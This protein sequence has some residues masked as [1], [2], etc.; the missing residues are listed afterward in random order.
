[1]HKRKGFTLIELLVVIAIIAL[2]MAILM[3]ALKRAK[4]QAKDVVCQSNLRHWGIVFNMYSGDFDDKLM[5]MNEYNGN[6]MSHAW[7]TLMYPYY[8]TFDIC[9]CPSAIYEWSKMVNYSHPLA[10]W[11]FRI[12]EDDLII[13]E[14]DTYYLVGNEYAYG[15]YGKNP[16]VSEPSTDSIGDDFY[17]YKNYFQTVLI[18]NASRTPLFGDCNYTG[19]FPHVHDEPVETWLHGPVD[20]TPPGEINRW[21]L[22]RH[23]LSVNLLFLDYSVRKVGLKQLWQLRWSKEDGWGNLDPV[24]WPEWMRNAKN[25]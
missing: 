15:S 3:P 11:D 17:S 20:L 6:W 5:D 7:V 8:R 12:L 14:F 22:D 24:E 21:N 10:A 9:M 18:K 19:G 1:M 25:Y 23:N 4:D 2:L 13:E 16:W